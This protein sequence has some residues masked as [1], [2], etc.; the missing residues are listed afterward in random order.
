MAQV[1]IVPSG[2]LVASLRPAELPDGASPRTYDTDFLAARVMQRS[3]LNNPFTYSGA[4]VGPSPGGTA[5]DTSLGGAVWSNP[6]NVLTNTG[7]YASASLSPFTL[8]IT[9]V[10]MA[11]TGTSFL[12]TVLTLTFASTPPAITAG[13]TYSISGLTNAPQLNGLIFTPVTIAGNSVTFS[14]VTQILPTYSGADSGIATPSGVLSQTDAIDI[15]QFGFSI[16]SNQTPQGFVVSILTYVNSASTVFGQ[17]SVQLLKAGVPVGT[18]VTAFSSLGAPATIPVGGMNNLFGSGWS[19]SDLNSTTFGL[20]ITYASSGTATIFIGYVTLQAYFVP[21]AANFNYVGQFLSPT[22]ISY[23]LALDAN[24]TWYLENTTSNPGV[25]TPILVGST[26]GSYGSGAT[27]YDRAFVAN[28]TLTGQVTGTDI[29]RQYNFEGGWWDRITQV[30]PASPGSVTASQASGSIANITS[31]TFTGSVAEI[32]ATNTYVAGEV[33]TFAGLTG[34]ASGLNGQTLIVLSTG[35]SGSGFQVASTIGAGGPFSQ[36]GATFTPQYTYPVATITQPEANSDITDP[37]HL[38][39]LLWSAGPGSTSAGNT[40]TVYYSPSYY[41]GSPQPIAQDTVLVAAFNAGYP[42]YVYISGAPYGNGIYQVTSI[43]NAL[44]PGVDHYRYYFTVQLPTSSYQNTVESTGQYQITQATVTTSTPVPGLAPGAQVSIAGA[45]VSAWDGVYPIVEAINAGAYNITQTALSGGTATYTWELV[46]G[47]APTSGQLVTVSNTLNANGVLNVTDA[48]IATATGVT[49]GTF[50]ITGFASSL[51]FPT[52]V[53]EGQATTAGTQFIVDPGAPN[54]GSTTVNPI[55]GNS[56]GGTITVVGSATGGTLPIGAGTRQA[57]WIFITRNGLY[58]APSP[59]LTYDVANGA[60]YVQVSAPIGPPNVIARLWAT[61]QAGQNGVPGAN[62]YTT[63]VPTLFTVGGVQYTS[64]SFLVPDNVTTTAR[65]TFSDF[66]LVESDA[67]DVVGNNLFNLIEL[68][69]PAVILQYATRTFYIGCQNKI[70][71]FL[72]LSFDG[73]YNATSGGASPTPLGWNLDAA[74]NLVYEG[75]AQSIAASLLV[76]PIFGNSLYVVNNSGSSQATLGMI[77]QSAYQD[78]WNEPILNPQ[79]SPVPYSFRITARTPSG[80]TTGNIVIDLTNSNQG[81]YGTTLA[82]VS[83]PLA[84]LTT[85]FQTYT[86]SLVPQ[87]GL[88][89]IP[90]GLLL[91]IW[92]QNIA[93]GGDYEIDRIEVFPTNQ[94]VLTN[95]VWVSYAEEPEQVDIDT[96]QL[97]L[98]SANQFPV[99]GAT[100]IQ[101]QLSFKKATSLIEV[102]DAANYEPSYWTTREIS[103]AGSGAVGPNAFSQGADWDISLHQTGINVFEGGKPMPISRELQAMQTG[104][105]LWDQINWQV[106]QTFWLV[107]DLRAR[108]FYVGVA[109]NTPNFWLPNAPTVINPT[110][111]NVYLMC[112]YDGCATAQ[113]LEGAPPVHVTMFGNLKAMDMRRKWSIGQISSPFAA[114][115]ADGLQGFD[116]IFLCNG[117]QTGKIYRLLSPDI[118]PTDD[119]VPIAPLYTTSGQP[120]TEKAQAM[121]IGSGQKYVAK[122]MANMQGSAVANGLTIRHY[123]NLLPPLWSTTGVYQAGQY[124]VYQG[125]IWSAVTPMNR[126]PPSSPNWAN[127]TAQFTVTY[128]PPLSFSMTNNIEWRKEVRGQRVFTEFS[129]NQSGTPVA[130][131]FELGEM[132]ADFQT[133]PWG[134]FRGASS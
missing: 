100:V 42:V 107:N 35:L 15:K 75:F 21:D 134:D 22:G 5:V 62:F 32:T 114:I 104:D 58:T 11:V 19:Y 74:S 56:T 27:V 7:L 80:Q 128:T 126:V 86:F 131:Y 20:R 44:P 103:Q 24:G 91:R 132:M 94:P 98:N 17:I 77:T 97:T 46:S 37:G 10:Q 99:Y 36:S 64:S 95:V 124:A 69:N 118:Q 34:G 123:P 92:G 50:A 70:Q 23:K 9:N 125:Q 51:N 96:G 71:N 6:A 110:Q 117:K 101:D 52:A 106:S 68:G 120:G 84:S 1:S 130:G 66:V 102:E 90:A 26:A 129:M 12:Q 73:G 40:L 81:I 121:Q 60:N 31:V 28:S 115:C 133:H 65:F 38:S 59:P 67:I 61:T 111:P 49:S 119:G 18:P 29:P 122:W 3:G 54:V 13:Q 72:N 47:I 55:Y 45:S 2:G 48:L 82:S 63:T 30:G 14:P 87:P 76:S 93:D 43:G 83:I 33:G 116:T 127:V 109:M 88:P 112:N 89:T 16:P 85:D 78:V 4:S 53:E 25:L 113:E 108:R 105:Q 8:T 79:G 39:V 41:G 57:V